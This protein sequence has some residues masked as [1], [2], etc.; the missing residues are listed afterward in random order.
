MIRFSP[1]VAALIEARIPQKT[2]RKLNRYSVGAQNVTDMSDWKKLLR[3][4]FLNIV[5]FSVIIVSIIS[6][7]VRYIQPMFSAFSGSR[8]LTAIIT[9]IIM[10]PFLWALAFRRMQRQAY[11]NVWVKPAQRGPLLLLMLLRIALAVFYVGLLFE[12]LYSHS[13]AMAGIIISGVLTLVFYKRIR[14]FYGRIELRFLSNLNE[15][16]ENNDTTHAL[17]PW[18]THLSRF[19]LTPQSPYIGKTLQESMIR[20]EFGVNIA[21]IE[22]GELTINVPSREE[23]LFPYD[24]ISVIGTDE[25]LREFKNKIESSVTSDTQYF[26][27][28]QS[29]SLHHF[30]ITRTSALLGKSI[31]HSGIRERTKGLVV[32]VEREG[33]RILNPESD[34]VF[35]MRDIVWVV[36]NARRIMVLAKEER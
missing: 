20:E 26:Q 25:Q 9:L 36:G 30:V 1:R 5:V 2:L 14:N 6:L 12:R 13:F 19:E 35:Q 18:D 15:R 29:V 10:A 31:R 24:K 17:A 4:Y 22:R 33:K 16:E 21:V 27:P 7:S 3:F 28:R 32:G 23:R 34:L 11:A 8:V